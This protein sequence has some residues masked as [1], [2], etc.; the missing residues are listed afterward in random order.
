[1]S[2]ERKLLIVED[3]EAQQKLYERAFVKEGYQVVLAADG[4]EA[5]EKA[6]TEQPDLIVMDIR[7]PR[8]DGIDAMQQILGEN[9]SVPVVIHTAYPT[10][11][12][13]FIR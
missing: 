4:T 1:M 5:I 6:Q 2:E 13:N 12:Q 7:M 11:Q 3:D 9:K 8:R 10:H